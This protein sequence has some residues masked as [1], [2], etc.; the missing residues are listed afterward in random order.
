MSGGFTLLNRRP[1][2]RRKVR[3]GQVRPE[4][5]GDF[6]PDQFRT[7]IAAGHGQFG[8]LDRKGPGGFS[9]PRHDLL[10]DQG[11]LRFRHHFSDLHPLRL[12]RTGKPAGLPA[13]PIA[14]VVP[15][16]DA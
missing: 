7:S 5:G 13:D 10:G 2:R 4:R 3:L 8:L 11:N 9:T 15:V 16:H 12:V 1:P 14:S 6:A